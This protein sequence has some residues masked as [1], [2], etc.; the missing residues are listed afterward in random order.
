MV[1]L[2]CEY[3]KKDMDWSKI[4]AARVL[5]KNDS[6]VTFCYFFSMGKYK[7]KLFSNKGKQC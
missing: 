2:C 5:W 6:M 3:I 4:L 7:E 1:N